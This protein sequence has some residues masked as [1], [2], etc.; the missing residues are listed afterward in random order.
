MRTRLVSFAALLLL[1]ACGTTASPTPVAGDARL[2]PTVPPPAYVEPFQPITLENISSLRFLGRLDAPSAPTTVFTGAISLDGVRLA[3]LNNDLLVGWDLLTGEVVFAT[4]RL[5]AD[6][7]F[8]SAD[9]SEVYTLT[10][11]GTARVYE[12]EQGRTQDDFSVSDEF[13]GL[14]SFHPLRGLLAVLGGANNL[15]IWDMLERRALG[16]FR[17]GEAAR[18][19]QIAFSTSGDLVAVAG[20]DETVELWDWGAQEI[21]A[22]LVDPDTATIGKL[23]FSPDDTQIAVGTTQNIMVWDTATAELLYTLQTGEGGISSTLLYTPDGRYIVNSGAPQ[24]AN[25]WNADTGTIAATLPGVG[26]TRTGIAASPSGDLLLSSVFEGPVTVWN[27]QSITETELG[28]ADL[29]VNV[30][31]I[32]VDWTEDGRTLVLYGARGSVY[33]WGIGEGD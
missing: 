8:F 23:V 13:G 25:V 17:V 18:V 30:D 33:I 31:I 21:V 6:M 1:T 4:S 24:T 14:S 7:V 19:T 26:Q 11:D 10:P 2:Q 29:D 32:G 9:K 12:G 22:T 27:L 28:R 16:T 15:R 5:E 3:G 20:E